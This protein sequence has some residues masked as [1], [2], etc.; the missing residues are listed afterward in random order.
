MDEELNTSPYS[1][2]VPGFLQNLR[3]VNYNEVKPSLTF[4]V[5]APVPALSQVKLE[6]STRPISA[7]TDV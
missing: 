5:K 7:I 1:I 4:T 6:G 3:A 2:S